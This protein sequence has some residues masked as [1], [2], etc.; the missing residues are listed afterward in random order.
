MKITYQIKFELR[1]C[2][3]D[4]DYRFA[5]REMKRAL[6]EKSLERVVSFPRAVV[7]KR[8]GKT[9]TIHYQTDEQAEF[10]VSV[11]QG[12]VGYLIKKD[13]IRLVKTEAGRTEEVTLFVPE[14]VCESW[15][16]KESP[17]GKV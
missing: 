11:L 3:C 9:V 5:L 16:S 17:V 2:D 10:Y 4:D 8:T 1:N 14:A 6:V 7:L 12:F 13:T 15:R